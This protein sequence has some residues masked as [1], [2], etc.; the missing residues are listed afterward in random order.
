MIEALQSVLRNIWQVP[1]KLEMKMTYTNTLAVSVFTL[2]LSGCDLITSSAPQAAI[3]AVIAH[4]SD[5]RNVGQVIYKDVTVAFTT[6]ADITPAD[7]QN[8][9]SEKYF[10]GV[11]YVFVPPGGSDWTDGYSCYI[12]SKENDNWVAKFGD[13][14]NEMKKQKIC[15]RLSF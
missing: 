14:R 11:D 8:A 13:D 3:D 12:V 10:I 6:K 9:I 1:R 2:L 5:R 4:V 7:K 15:K